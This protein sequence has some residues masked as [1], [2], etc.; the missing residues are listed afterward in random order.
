MVRGQMLAPAVS[1]WC[2]G[3]VLVWHFCRGVGQQELA[4]RHRRVSFAHVTSAGR[5]KCSATLLLRSAGSCDPGDSNNSQTLASSL[6]STQTS[7]TSV[8]VT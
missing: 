6:S 8:R 1:A 7:N 3:E 2:A 5:N 4:G